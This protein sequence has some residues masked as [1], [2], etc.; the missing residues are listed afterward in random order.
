MN[1]KYTKGF[2]LIELLIVVGIIGILLTAGITSYS[3]TLQRTRDERR[4]ANLQNIRSQLELFKS[5][6]PIGVYP[7]DLSELEVGGY[8]IPEDPITKDTT[9][10]V[11]TPTSF[12]SWLTCNNVDVNRFCQN[13]Q[14]LVPLEIKGNRYV[15]R[16]N[17]ENLIP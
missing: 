14:L 2:T 9:P 15:V 3:T 1:K 5:T 7:V 4:I 13:Y 11:Y 16:P 12:Q 10:Y 8:Q 6:S 17:G